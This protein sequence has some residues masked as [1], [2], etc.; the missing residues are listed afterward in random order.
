MSNTQKD[1]NNQE[2][3]LNG[4]NAVE[5]EE[6]KRMEIEITKY[7]KIVETFNHPRAL[8]KL[9]LVFATII[10][11]VFLGVSLI[12]LI[13]KSYYPYKAVNSNEYGAT[14]IR[15]ED[16]EVIYWLFNT[17]DLWANSGI[18]VKE[19]EIISVRT[20]GAANTAIHHL[21]K[22]ADSNNKLQ[23]PWYNPNGRG[24]YE[25]DTSTKKRLKHKI[26]PKFEND[27]ILMQIVPSDWQLDRNDFFWTRNNGRD[28]TT[29]FTD[30]RNDKNINEDLYIYAIGDKNENIRIPRD[31]ILYFAVNDIA[32]TPTILASMLKEDSG[33]KNK[34]LLN[35]GKSPQKELKTE[36]HYYK[37]TKFVDAWYVDNVGSFLIVIERKK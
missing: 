10:I 17:A 6:N 32:L 16:D 26:A 15:N 12:A 14:F 20:S 23:Y 22:D 37:E 31:G 30:G 1:I 21:V 25:F 4:N 19:G 3:D 2:S 11:L 27:I 9:I 5:K 8:A 34:N 7:K 35:L 33:V 18:E 36:L 29:C 28:S 24:H 13:V